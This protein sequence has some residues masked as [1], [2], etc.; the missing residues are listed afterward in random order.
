MLLYNSALQNHQEY[1]SSR[2]N[3]KLQVQV[4]CCDPLFHSSNE[5]KVC[6]S[7]DTSE[8]RAV[9]V[10]YSLCCRKQNSFHEHYRK[11]IF[12]LAPQLQVTEKA[13]I[14]KNPQKPKPN[15]QTSN[16]EK[17][18]KLHVYKFKVFLTRKD[19]LKRQQICHFI[20]SAFPFSHEG[21]HVHIHRFRFELESV[22]TEIKTFGNHSYTAE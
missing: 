10:N 2:Q 8:Q 15:K 7:Q 21:T 18:N 6:Q 4:T 5:T 13:A 17:Q 11:R 12:F 9:F 19:I 3:T 14:K 22:Y 16:H 20:P 1:V